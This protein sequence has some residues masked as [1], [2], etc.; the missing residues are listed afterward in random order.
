[1]IVIGADTHMRSHTVAAVDEATGGALGDRTVPTE[2]KSFDELVP[3]ARRLADPERTWAPED[4]RHVSSAL[5]R[6][7]LA[8]GERVVRVPP[9]LSLARARPDGPPASLT[10]STR[11]RSRVPRCARAWT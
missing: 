3:W 7:L 5:E 1:M 8:R 2:R 4:C 9:K 10:R 11:S 6:F